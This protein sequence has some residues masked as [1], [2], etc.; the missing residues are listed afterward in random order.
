LPERRVKPEKRANENPIFAR[1][2]GISQLSRYPA[3]VERHARLSS[4]GFNVTSGNGGTFEH[5]AAT[6]EHG[7]DRIF[8][9]AK[10]RKEG[11]KGERAGE[12]GRF[13]NT[14]GISSAPRY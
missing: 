9:F 2:I 4:P 8:F 11:G 1:S 6:G 7:R 3:P 13:E 5:C 12:R 14:E 10:K